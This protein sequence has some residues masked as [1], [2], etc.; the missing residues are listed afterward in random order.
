MRPNDFAWMTWANRQWTDPSFPNGPLTSKRVDDVGE[1]RRT[2][3]H[4]HV[5]GV[6]IDDL[7]LSEVPD[8]LVLNLEAKAGIT[9]E[10]Y[11][12]AR[13]GLSQSRQIRWFREHAHRFGTES[14]QRRGDLILVHVVA[15]HRSRQIW[16]QAITIDRMVTDEVGCFFDGGAEVTEHIQ[17]CRALSRNGA[18]DKDEASKPSGYQLG[19]AG[20]RESSHRVADQCDA[21]QVVL[22]DLIRDRSGEIGKRQAGQVTWGAPS[23]WKINGIC[24]PVQEGT[25]LS[26]ACPREA[27][28][29]NQN[30]C[31]LIRLSLRNGGS[32]GEE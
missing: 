7:C 25:N 29:M 9:Q 1:V 22:Q 2:T 4:C 5:P 3:D 19:H 8:H 20:E 27:T 32:Q 15:E 21:A 11:V 23:T 28:A 17:Q 6:E 14:A 12:R 10:A 26:P 18:R 24:R 30:V 16:V 13:N 31:H